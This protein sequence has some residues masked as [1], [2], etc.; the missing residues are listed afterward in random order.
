MP[1]GPVNTSACR[2]PGVIVTG[3]SNFA[4]TARRGPVKLV[5]GMLLTI[6]M[7]R[8]VAVGFPAPSTVRIWT[9][10]SKL[11][12]LA[13]R[14]TCALVSEVPAGGRNVWAN[15]WLPVMPAVLLVAGQIPGP[16][17]GGPGGGPGGGGGDDGDDAAAMQVP[18]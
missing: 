6:V 3:G 17:G 11:I 4:S 15:R 14:T 9:V 8:L 16:T 5:A 10:S 13:R 2:W 1:F 18:F 7:P 12:G